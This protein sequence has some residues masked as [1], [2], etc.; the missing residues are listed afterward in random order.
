[1]LVRMW[2]S[3]SSHSLLVGT[4]NDAAAL[5]DSLAVSSLTKLNI[6]IPYDPA[7]EFLGVYP[8]ESRTYDHI[9]I[10]TWAFIKLYSYLSKLGSN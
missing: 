3:R 1:M 5:E 8:K 4:Q 7:I 9:Q 2:S 10:Y 6:P